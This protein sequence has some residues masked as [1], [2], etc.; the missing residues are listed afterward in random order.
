MLSGQDS[1][2]KEHHRRN[3][4]DVS[5]DNIHLTPN[6][7]GIVRSSGSSNNNETGG[8]FNIKLQQLNKYNDS[9]KLL[10]CKP[11]PNIITRIYL[12]LMN[13]IQEIEGFMKCKPG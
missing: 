13:Y 3:A 4:S 11:D 7:S 2:K 6:S 1:Q 5:S 12:P 9:N 8:S 10:I